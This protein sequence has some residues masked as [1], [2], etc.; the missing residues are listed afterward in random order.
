MVSDGVVGAFD[1][2]VALGSL[3][4]AI[5]DLIERVKNLPE[6]DF[7]FVGSIETVFEGMSK[8]FLNGDFVFFQS[9]EECAQFRDSDF[10][11]FCAIPLAVESFDG[12]EAYLIRY[13]QQWR[14]VWKQWETT[15]ISSVVLDRQIFADELSSALNEFANLSGP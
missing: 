15:T 4:L 7:G 13:G 10:N 12:E 5:K 3:E 1:Q 6:C 11:K 14:F 8:A 9:I 2:Y